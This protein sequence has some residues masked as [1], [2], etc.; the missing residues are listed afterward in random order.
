MELMDQLRH[1][2]RNGEN[3]KLHKLI[4]EVREQDAPFASTLRDLADRYEYDALT[5]LLEKAPS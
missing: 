2:V 3:D 4:E 1:A 5:Q